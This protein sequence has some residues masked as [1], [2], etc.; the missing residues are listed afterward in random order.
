MIFC[1]PCVQGGYMREYQEEGQ[2]TLDEVKMDEK[3]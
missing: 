2:N 3:G 1:A